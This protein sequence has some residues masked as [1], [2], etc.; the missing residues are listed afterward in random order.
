[1]YGSALMAF[2]HH[3]AAFT[4]VASLA[5]EVAMFKP[6]LS[7]LQARRLQRTDMLFGAAATV[8]LV[9][10]MLRVAFFEKGPAY[11]WHDTYFLIKSGAFVLAALISIYPTMIFLS[12]NRSLKAGTPPDVPLV[13]MRRVRICLMLELSA[14]VVILLCAALMARGFGYR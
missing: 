1:M 4:L 2:V 5:V 3:L 11:Y 6:P 9:V 12:W 8:V 7:M 10:G 14:F 13:R